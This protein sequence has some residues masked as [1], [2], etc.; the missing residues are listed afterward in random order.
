MKR[1]QRSVVKHS[2]LMLWRKKF[3]QEAAEALKLNKQIGK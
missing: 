3:M 2:D 1:K